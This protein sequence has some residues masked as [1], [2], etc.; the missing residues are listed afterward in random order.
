MP[1]KNSSCRCI[2]FIAIQKVILVICFLSDSL[3]KML[4]FQEG[5]LKLNKDYQFSYFIIIIQFLHA[6]FT[7]PPF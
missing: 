4:P 2:N 6:F 7:I 5:Y 1:A 3:H